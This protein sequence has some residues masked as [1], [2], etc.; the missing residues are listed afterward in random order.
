MT[1]PGVHDLV[2]ALREFREQWQCDQV[3]AS[4][5][6]PTGELVTLAVLHQLVTVED[7]H[8][9]VMVVEDA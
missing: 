3:T 9:H 4:Y 2:A 7:D 5:V 6:A 1:D 8:G